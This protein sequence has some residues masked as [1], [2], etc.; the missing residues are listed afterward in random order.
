VTDRQR[1][2]SQLQCRSF[3]W[4]L[5]NVYPELFIP[6]D[7]LASGEVSIITGLEVA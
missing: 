4:Y 5:K 3:D 7:A 1:L 2:R 6:S